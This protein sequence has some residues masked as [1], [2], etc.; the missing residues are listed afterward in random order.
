M[1]ALGQKQEFTILRIG[2]SLG[3]LETKAM[4]SG[5]FEPTSYGASRLLKESCVFFE[6]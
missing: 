5:A 6:Q 2:I 3:E 1:L 4:L